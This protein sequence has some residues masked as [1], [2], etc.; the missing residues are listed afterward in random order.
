MRQKKIYTG[1]AVWLVS[2]FLLVE[3]GSAQR[4]LIKR[5]DIAPDKDVVKIARK[6]SSLGVESPEAI[7]KLAEKL[8]SKNVAVRAA[9]V[10]A[11][12]YLGPVSTETI[13][14]IFDSVGL[15]GV[16]Y[17]D[18]IPYIKIA[19]DALEKI[20]E[21]TIPVA[22]ERLSS[23]DYLEYAVAADLIHRLGPKASAAVP[24][25][26]TR[27]GPGKHQFASAFALEGIGPAGEP[28][29]DKL[30]KMLDSKEF[31]TVCIACRALGAIGPAASRAKEKLLKVAKNGNVSERGRAMQALGGI[32]VVSDEDVK[33]LFEKNLVAFHQSIKERTVLGLGRLGKE[34]GK[35]FI[36]WLEKAIADTRY[37]NK[38]FAAMS[39]YQVGGSK[40]LVV[41]T[42]VEAM[43]DPTFELDV[44]RKLGE[45]GP[46][47]QPALPVLKKYLESDDDFTRA[48]VISSL[49]KIGLDQGIRDKLKEI[50]QIGGYQSAREALAALKGDAVQQEEL[51]RAEKL[52]LHKQK[53][54]EKKAKTTNQ[55]NDE[56]NK[57]DSKGGVDR[58]EDQ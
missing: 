15:A 13:N 24:A 39:L 16:L 42:L 22:I 47:A 36:P 28:A 1:L 46:D 14:A 49:S 20:G 12:P 43:K 18:A 4:E 38:P 27:L 44:I 58:S 53:L 40:S 29:I 35:D 17:P 57:S 56:T 19:G 26:L 31:N 32:G 30:I 2:A 23:K 9:C 54:A 55:S 45:L 7:N 41:K 6:L 11:I 5:L 3:H 52:K 21:K 34:K 33:P 25:L 51:E 48:L 50:S 10:D 37:H 8:Q